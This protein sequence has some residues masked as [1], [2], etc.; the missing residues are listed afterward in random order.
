MKRSF[1]ILAVDDCV[2]DVFLLGEALRKAGV[3]TCL[4]AV[5][6][7][8]AA[9]AYLEG[10]DEF[11]DR[12]Q[13]PFPDFL[14]LDLNMPRMN[15][16]ELLEAVRRHPVYNRLMICVLTASTLPAD[17]DRAYRLGANLYLTKPN[18]L[19]ELVACVHGLYGVFQ[20]ASLPGPASAQPGR[21]ATARSGG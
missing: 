20:Y 14:L 17:V 10:G 2:D 15:G 11:A 3:P 8:V 16:F 9:L 21:R 12:T 7:G 13:H 5:N 19:D 4:S 1:N 18:R 6:D